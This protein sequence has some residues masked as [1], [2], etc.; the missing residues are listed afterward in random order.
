MGTS[1]WV[2]IFLISPNY[3]YFKISL[4]I[5]EGSRFLGTVTLLQCLHSKCSRV[6]LSL[7]RTSS[8]P[9]CHTSWKAI[10]HHSGSQVHR[11]F[12]KLYC[13][14]PCVPHCPPSVSP[15][16][17]MLHPYSLN[18]FPAIVSFSPLSFPPATFPRVG[19]FTVSHTS[20][21]P[22]ITSSTFY[23]RTSQ[24]PLEW[25][26]Q[27]HLK[28]HQRQLRAVWSRGHHRTEQGSHQLSL[29]VTMYCPLH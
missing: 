17:L 22:F 10:C 9:S 25:N 15:G 18:I 2:L 5:S 8:S 12:L 20:G 6:W 3:S 28:A 26:L 21:L 29:K 27:L 14:I 24:K 19:C 16:I 13:S 11:A 4:R 7:I 23:L 1:L